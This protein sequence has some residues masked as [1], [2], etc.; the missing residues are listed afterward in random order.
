MLPP[1]APGAYTLFVGIDIAAKTATAAWTTGDRNTSHPL[2]IDQTPHGYAHLHSQLQ[3]T[4]HAPATTLV[5][6]EATGTYWIT[7]ALTLVG[8]GYAV[9]VINPR[10]AHNFAK[11]LLKR[12]K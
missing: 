1:A 6:M 2:T 12:A 3:T 4:G 9:S 5:V 8:W 11:A 7:L 10:Q